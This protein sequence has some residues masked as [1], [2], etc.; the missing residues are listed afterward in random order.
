M[1]R[2]RNLVD[3]VAEH[4]AKL[5]LAHGIGEALELLRAH[6]KLL[7]FHQGMINLLGSFLALLLLGLVVLLGL[8]LDP[9]EVFGRVRVER[10]LVFLITCLCGRF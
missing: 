3:V 9:I 8:G 4:T 7:A 6:V 2:I 1:N 5:L 10:H